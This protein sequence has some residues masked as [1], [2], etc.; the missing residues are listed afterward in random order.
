VSSYKL[1]SRG[2][3]A[4][5]ERGTGAGYFFFIKP[6]S[7]LIFEFHLLQRQKGHG[8]RNYRKG[9]G[10]TCWALQ[11]ILDSEVLV[12]GDT[13]NHIHLLI[14]LPPKL[15]LAEAVQKP[16]ANSSRWLG[17]NET[18]FEWQKGYGAFSVSPS[19]LNIVQ[20]YIRHQAEHHQKRNFEEKFLTLL[21][22]SGVPYSAAHTFD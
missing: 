16:P 6:A 2:K 11:K 1:D 20:A 8:N 21:R 9:S 4:R 18:A 3:V 14:A 12:A 7:R 17:E 13:T 5:F 22:K 10:R 15:P 19:L